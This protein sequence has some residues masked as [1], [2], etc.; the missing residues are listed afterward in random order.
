MGI[1]VKNKDDEII[2]PVKVFNKLFDQLGTR[3]RRNL[4]IINKACETQYEIGSKDFSIPTIAKLVSD[5]G[6]PAEQT[7]RNSS[8]AEYRALM[9]VWAE[10]ANGSTKKNSL[11]EQQKRP[12]LD[13]DILNG[14]NDNTTKALVRIILSEN[15][16][17]KKKLEVFQAQSFVIDMRV[18][19]NQ[20]NNDIGTNST[21][22]SLPSAP[23]LKFLTDT[24]L[25]SLKDAISDEVMEREGWIKERNGRVKSQSGMAVFKIG[26]VN[27]IKKILENYDK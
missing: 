6:G 14:I 1:I 10:Y 3:K 8:G 2:K 24:E 23:D 19:N 5:K 25:D 18:N 26:F 7:L 21:V 16:T 17:L 22:G 13:D 11:K 12:T 15:K 9:N 20:N 4:E 27:A